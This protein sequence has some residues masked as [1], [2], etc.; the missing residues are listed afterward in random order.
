[1]EGFTKST[2]AILNRPLMLQSVLWFC[3]SFVLQKLTNISTNTVSPHIIPPQTMYF[4][5]KYN[6]TVSVRKSSHCSLHAAQVLCHT[7][8]FYMPS[9]LFWVI[10]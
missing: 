4:Q 5:I 8:S 9:V 2:V 3:F 6:K 1:M 7:S 10:F